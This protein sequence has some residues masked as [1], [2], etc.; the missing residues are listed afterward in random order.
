M[1][2]KDEMK[3]LDAAAIDKELAK[4]RQELLKTKLQTVDQTSKETH[5]LKAHR[6]QI[7]RL[8]TLKGSKQ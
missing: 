2:T 7:A 6:K 8:E 1:M 4:S 3:G 5:L